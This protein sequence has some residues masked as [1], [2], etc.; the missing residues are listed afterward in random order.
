MIITKSVKLE[1]NKGNI[2]YYKK[3]NEYNNIKI[4]DIVDIDIKHLSKSNHSKIKY[5]CDICGAEKE[6]SYN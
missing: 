2:P 1:I 5:I 3:F 4:G 6:T